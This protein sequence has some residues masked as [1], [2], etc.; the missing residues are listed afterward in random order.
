LQ[1]S[2]G[3]VSLAWTRA[4]D[5]AIVLPATTTFSHPNNNPK[6]F[7]C[8]QQHTTHT[9]TKKTQ[10]QAKNHLKLKT[11]TS[12]TWK[13]LVQMTRIPNSEHHNSG[14]N[15]V[16]WKNNGTEQNKDIEVSPQGNT[17]IKL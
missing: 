17:K 8:S 4:T 11:L 15:L 5:P 16:S 7:T 12:L 1:V 2:S 13:E 9:N 6:H 3:R 10:N 14:N